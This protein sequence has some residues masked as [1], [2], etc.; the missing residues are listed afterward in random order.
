[1][2]PQL[3]NEEAAR[4]RACRERADKLTRI[5]VIEPRFG[6]VLA[7]APLESITTRLTIDL[8]TRKYTSTNQIPNQQHKEKTL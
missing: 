7:D 3:S 5:C 1:M 8:E 2:S 6:D 4:Y